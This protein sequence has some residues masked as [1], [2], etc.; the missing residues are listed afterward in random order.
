MFSER[1]ESDSYE[2]NMRSIVLKSKIRPTLT[3]IIPPTGYVYYRH[4]DVIC[5]II[6]I[7]SEIYINTSER[8]Q[9]TMNMRVKAL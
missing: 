3:S 2:F 4:V 8:P 6:K 1:H 7:I 9:L 5:V